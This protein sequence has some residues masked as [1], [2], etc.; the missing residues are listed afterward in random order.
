MVATESAVMKVEALMMRTVAGI[1]TLPTTQP[2]R[3]HII[4]PRI[5]R[6]DGVNIPP[7]VPR[8]STMAEAGATEKGP[9]PAI[10]RSAAFIEGSP[11][12]MAVGDPTPHPLRP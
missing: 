8:P 6:F 9:D 11:A 10:D 3:S 5:V 4:T 2:S 1:P 7:N 12:G